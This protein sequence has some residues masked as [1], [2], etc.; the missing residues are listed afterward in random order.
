LAQRQRQDWR[1]TFFIVIHFW[2]IA[3]V[4]ERQSRCPL[5]PVLGPSLSNDFNDN[6]FF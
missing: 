6:T 4:S 1:D 3:L 5:E 2:Q